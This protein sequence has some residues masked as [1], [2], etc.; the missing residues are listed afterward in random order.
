MMSVETIYFEGEPYLTLEAL[1]DVYQVQV[2]WLREIYQS[3]LLGSGVDAGT[4]ICIAAV[5]LDRVA[6]IVRLRH[7]VGQ[8]VDAISHALGSLDE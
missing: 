2:V 1:A 4:T 8:D 3:G 7:F 5:Q 6:T